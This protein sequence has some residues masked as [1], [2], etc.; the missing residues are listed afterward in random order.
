MGLDRQLSSRQP[1][2]LCLPRRLFYE[3]LGEERLGWG[4]IMIGCH[5]LLLLG[6]PESPLCP[7][8]L[9]YLQGMQDLL[10]STHWGTHSLALAS[11]LET[12]LLLRDT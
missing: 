4:V 12:Q 10:S 1:A 11:T 5:L 9:L 6:F 7:R 3:R 2:P 8:A